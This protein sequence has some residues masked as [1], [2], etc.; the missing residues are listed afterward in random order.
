[1]NKEKNL[2][3]RFSL[4]CCFLDLLDDDIRKNI[5]LSIKNDNLFMYSLLCF[6]FSKSEKE[7]LLFLDEIDKYIKERD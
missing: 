7:K 6:Y 1:M 4:I 2:F 5:L 3:L